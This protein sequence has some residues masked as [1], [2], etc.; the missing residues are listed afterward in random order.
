MSAMTTAAAA[1][2]VGAAALED[3]AVAAAAAALSTLVAINHCS[4]GERH[5]G[6][7]QTSHHAE[8]R[9]TACL[10]MSVS[11][12]TKP[13]AMRR[14]TALCTSCPLSFTSSAQLYAAHKEL[15]P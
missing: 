9:Q 7:S 3:V 12:T 4:L 5:A 11:S 14:G 13:K 10:S 2:A 15:F 6:S 1:A 8:I